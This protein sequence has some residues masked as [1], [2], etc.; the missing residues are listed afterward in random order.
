[1]IQDLQTRA[2]EQSVRLVMSVQGD[3]YPIKGDKHYLYR[4][5]FNLVTNAICFSPENGEVVVVLEFS[6][7]E[8]KIQVR[9][10]GPGVPPEELAD[11]FDRYMRAQQGNNETNNL[12][13]GL[14]IVRAVAEAHKGKVSARNLDDH[15]A[16]FT[17]TLPSS[18]RR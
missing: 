4:S 6:D 12:G 7:T 8:V 11:I 14:E 9:D 13:L 18:L 17:I 10:N 16:E 2:E 5:V 1:M 15:G 3:P